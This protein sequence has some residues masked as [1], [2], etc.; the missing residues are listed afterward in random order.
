MGM[1]DVIIV[2]A[3]PAGLYAA[4][5]CEELGLD[6]IVLEEHERI[7]KP[8]H[9]SGLVSANLGALIPIKDE[10]IENKIKG[11]IIHAP[12]G[13]SVKLEK[14]GTAAYVIDRPAFD[15]FLASR[16]KSGILIK[17]RVDSVNIENDR[18]IIGS[19]RRKYEASAV[20]G[21]DGS[22]SIIQREMNVKPK[23]KISGSIAIVKDSPGS[24][25][26]FVELW[27]DKN[28]CDGF[29]WKIPRGRSMEYGML[30]KS[31]SFTKL[32]DFFDLDSSY[33]RLGGTIPLG[34]PKS[35]FERVLL[36][37]DSAAQIKPWSGGGVIYSLMAAKIAASVIAKAKQSGDFRERFLER[38]EFAWK[39]KFGSRI[40]AGMLGKAVYDKM[41]NRRINAAISS[42]KA[43]R[44]LMNKLDMDFLV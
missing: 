15:C 3:G 43:A 31:P 5:C 30:S 18:I 20:L 8:G 12:N 9:C 10:F 39:N 25:S 27:F 44:I 19:G 28:I 14:K 36:V 1:H 24:D 13:K 42:A 16:I 2:G 21:C 11:A 29:V 26:K 41:G 33:E 23:E 17:T 7:G 35:F 37:G 22:N 32:E 34:P 38:Y 6:T 4:K 40:S